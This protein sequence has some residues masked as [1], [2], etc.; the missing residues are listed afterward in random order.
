MRGKKV[1][2]LAL[3]VLGLVGMISSN[4]IVARSAPVHLMHFSASSHQR[5]WQLTL[6][7]SGPVKYNAF[8]LDRPNRFVLDLKNT[9]LMRRVSPV[10]TLGSP[11][12]NIRIG[13]HSDH[14]LRLVFDLGQ[15][16]QGS[17]KLLR[18]QKK[19]GY[20]LIVSLKGRKMKVLAF[21]WP[22]SL[23]FRRKK[24]LKTIITPQWNKR[25][26]NII[27]VVDPGHGGSDPG[28]TGLG[29]THEK[30][31]VLAIS[32]AIARAMNRQPGFKA[33]LTRNADYYIG[34]RQRLSIARR[35]KAD[36][37]VA[38]HADAFKRRNA[39]AASV[40]ALSQRGATSEAARWLAIRENKSELMG[41]VNLSDK[42]HLLKSVLINLSQTATIRM[43]LGIG[44]DILHT[45]KKLTPLHHDTVEQAA[46]VV[47]KSPDIPSLLIETGF[48]SNPYE[49]RKLTSSR[50]QQRLARAIT[51]GIR[52]Y[53]MHRPPRGTWL[54]YWKK[55]PPRG[56][57]R[58]IVRRGNTLS[59]LSY[60][61]HANLERI[62]RLNGIEGHDIRVGQ[63]LLI[64]N[65]GG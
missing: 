1:K 32:K 45:L 53:F 13:H 20:R 7:L 12:R 17:V 65:R 5:V 8:S 18:L 28:A 50:Y 43:S 4:A 2:E 42:G 62:R 21:S 49:E 15:P 56:E 51:R 6:F 37:F 35:D 44:R 34:L 16:L 27:V 46:F 57:R 41:G 64:P 26:R 30:T 31:V 24:K 39:Y 61:F 40:Y 23:K 36:M 29:G 33:L 58:Y 14:A 19:K 60:R 10:L 48:I 54:A 52:D 38:I 25:P 63:V 3:L 55:N 47:L 11:V 9:R 22:S 59:G